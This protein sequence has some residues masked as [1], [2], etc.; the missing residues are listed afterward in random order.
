MTSPVFDMSLFRRNHVFAFSSLAAL[1]NYGASFAVGFLLS[2]YL[3]YT[4]GLQPQQAGIILVSQPVVMAFFSPLAGRLSDKVEP[5]VVA[6]TGM[7]FT[8][9]ALFMFSFLNQ[10][11]SL[12][13]VI[14]SLIVIGFG[15]ALFSSP[16]TNAIM[17]S[18]QKRSYGV[19]AATVGIVEEESWE[20]I[21]TGL[22]DTSA[23]LRLVALPGPNGSILLDDTYNASPASTIAAL[24]LLEEVPGRKIAVLGDMLELGDLE[25]EGHSTVGRRVLEVVDLLITVGR[26]GRTIGQEAMVCGMSEDQILMVEDNRAAIAHLR[27][28][29]GADDVVLVKG[30][31]GMAMEEIVNSL[32]EDRGLEA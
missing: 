17:S 28:M 10:N 24:N 30:S 26:L 1:I 22:Q 21:V 18:V 16:N 3:Q 25:A 15:L 4:K 9:V 2:L 32:T 14:I 13:F 6:S 11:T 27:R 20:E 7:A 19:A 29:V 5:R 8:T 31:R 12:A 23:H